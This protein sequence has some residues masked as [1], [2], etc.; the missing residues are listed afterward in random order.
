V[1]EIPA[2]SDAAIKAIDPIA[3]YGTTLKMIRKSIA[4]LDYGPARTMF[5]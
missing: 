2:E 5:V 3:N 1:C 4:A